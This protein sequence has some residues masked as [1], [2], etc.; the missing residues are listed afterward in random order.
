VIHD[1]YDTKVKRFHHGVAQKFRHHYAIG[2]P[3]G[4]S[5]HGLE[6]LQRITHYTDCFGDLVIRDDQ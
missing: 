5:C 1:S 2:N 3:E 6:G 4:M